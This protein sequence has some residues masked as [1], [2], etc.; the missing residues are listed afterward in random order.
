MILYR[1]LWTFAKREWSKRCLNWI[2]V[3]LKGKIGERIC[4]SFYSRIYDVC[5]KLRDSSNHLLNTFEPSYTKIYVAL[6]IVLR[7]WKT[8]VTRNLHK[9]NLL[10]MEKII[11]N[12]RN[13]KIN[14]ETV[15]IIRERFSRKMGFNNG[16]VTILRGNDRLAKLVK[17][18]GEEVI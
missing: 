1:I 15:E 6:I 10:I 4:R 18:R 11:F 3:C 2:D 13:S 16:M 9:K 8:H 5:N 7:L 12:S 17:R 14:R